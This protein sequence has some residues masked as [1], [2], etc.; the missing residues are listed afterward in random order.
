MIKEY[1]LQDGTK[2]YMFVAYLGVDPVTGKQKRTTRRG[3]ESEREA[4]LAEAR[5]LMEVDAH[6]FAGN[7]KATFKEVYELWLETYKTTVKESTWWKTVQIFENHILPNF[8]RLKV[9]NITVAYVQKQLNA[10]AKVYKKYSTF[11]N[12]TSQVMKFAANMSMITNNVC[13]KV[14]L[15]KAKT[16]KRSNNY[17]NKLQ[18]N[19][20]IK[21]WEK[22]NKPMYHT[23]FRL[24]AYSGMRTGEA[25]ALRW[26]DLNF[27]LNTVTINKGVTI[28]NNGRVLVSETPKNSHSERTIDLDRETIE[29]LTKWR[30]EQ[31]K[32]LLMDGYNA[33]NHEQLIFSNT[34]N[35]PIHPVVIANTLRRFIEKNNLDHI[36]PHGFRHTHCSLLL[37]AGVAIKEVQERLG[38]SDIKTTMNIYAHVTQK[39][40]TETGHK[41]AAFV[42]S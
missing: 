13:E 35:G 2:K 21:S 34:K 15:P 6:G 8:G 28:G 42:G 27:N 17:Y 26:T 14:I 23:F 24:L 3:F 31:K 39:E 38:H 32:L 7:N 41:F 9:K 40:E 33:L 11:L 12:Y 5:L 25:L 36:T 18:L 19:Q 1:K 22:E 10:W 37:E 29:V 4:K 16:K 30:K 20:F